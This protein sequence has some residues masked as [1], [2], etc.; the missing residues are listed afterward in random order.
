MPCSLLDL[1]DELH[2]NIIQELLQHDDL[3]L[4][5]S[6]EQDPNQESRDRD[7]Q[8]HYHR[9]LMNWSCTSHYFRNLLAPCIFKSI[10]LRNDE[11]SGASVDS[12]L[13]S[14]HGALVKEMYF[15][16]TIPSGMTS[17]DDDGDVEALA[18]GFHTEFDKAEEEEEKPITITLPLVV[19]NLLSDLHQ[20]PNL[21]SLSIGF[22]YP[23]E[24]PFDD[25]YDAEGIVDNGNPEPARAWK[26]LMTTTFET[27]LRNKPPQLRALEIRK[28]VW[29]YT[30]PYESQSFHKFLSQV[31]CFSLSVRGGNNGA[32]WCVSTCDGYLE[33]VARFDDLFFD[34]LASA[35]SLILKATEEGPI[36][37]EGMRHARL[38]LKKGQ[39]PLLKSLHLEHIFICQELVDLLISHTDTL[40]QLTLH[41]C[42]SS[43]NG[44]QDNAGFYW[45]HFFDALYRADLKKLSHLEIRPYNAPLY[46][47][48]SQE[49][50]DPENVQQIRRVLSEDAKR[51]VFG[52]ATLNDKYGDCFTDDDENQAA[53][54]RGEDQV[55]FDRLMGNIS[56]NATKGEENPIGKSA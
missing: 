28:F 5:K 29:T 7:D 53:F 8:F 47:S 10:K 25:Y 45:N 13:K 52:Y 33:C 48:F 43:V 2:L 35:T 46:Y 56:A 34:H 24:Y 12:L 11:K 41:D 1:S 3:L 55:A 23:Y 39:M 14:P 40:E 15:L 36:G 6:L 54:E 31:E 19:D 17:P 51:R 20:F 16:G 18:E 27:L 30:E 44:L 50:A 9:D 37:L 49:E 32:G 4:E 21:E 38:A 22:T 26:A 42:N